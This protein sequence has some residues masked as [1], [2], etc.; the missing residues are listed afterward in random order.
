VTTVSVICLLIAVYLALLSLETVSTSL[1]VKLDASLRVQ[2]LFMA[3]C[4]FV[5]G[6]I[7][8]VC[9]AI[10]SVMKKAS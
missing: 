1:G 9:L 5:T 4:F 8:L 3:T 6:I 2:F 10:R 7:L